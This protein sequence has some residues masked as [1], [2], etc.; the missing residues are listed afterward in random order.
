MGTNGISGLYSGFDTETAIKQMM[1]AERN[2]VN[3]LISSRTTLEWKKDA[4]TEWNNTLKKFREENMSILSDKVNM[5]S[6]SAYK[7]FSVDYSTPSQRYFSA[8]GTSKAQAGTY[9]V[10]AIHQLATGAK[11]ATSGVS[12]GTEGLK[13][14]NVRL[15]EADFLNIPKSHAGSVEVNHFEVTINGIDFTFQKSDTVQDVMN[16]IN[17]SD[18]GVKM[19][20]SQLTDGFTIETTKIGAGAELEIINKR[21]NLFGDYTDSS[22]VE[23][24]SVFGFSNMVGMSSSGAVSGSA[25]HTIDGY[26]GWDIQNIGNHLKTQFQFGTTPGEAIKFELS[27]GVSTETFA[28]DKTASINDIMD[29]V[30]NSSLNIKLAYNKVS[31]AFLLSRTDGDTSKDITVNNMEGNFFGGTLGAGITGIASGTI[32]AANSQLVEV[33][34]GKNA[35][36]TIND[37]L[38]ERESNSFAID[39]INYKLTKT[40]NSTWNSVTEEFEVTADEKS[41]DIELTQNVDEAVKNITNYITEINKLLTGIYGATNEKKDRDYAPLTDE[42]KEAMTE[43]E[44]ELWEAKAKQGQLRR[45]TYLNNFSSSIRSIFSSPI[46]GIGSMESIGIKIGTYLTGQSWQIEVDETK[47]REALEK[48]SNKV[49]EL[50]TH[51]YDEKTDDSKY[52]NDARY[53]ERV[54][55][56][57]SG[58]FKT[59]NTYESMSEAKKKSLNSGF[60][61]LI[62]DALTQFSD[63]VMAGQNVDINGTYTKL[64]SSTQSLTTRIEEY[65]ARIKKEEERLT[66]LEE[67]YWKQF[68]AMETAL[69]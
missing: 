24:K 57:A 33:T 27:D 38:V 62:S 56:R 17:S 39:E 37:V 12:K 52:I 13:D 7:S 19:A 28:F 6:T 9:T 65:S 67:R 63:E 25:E 18:A 55:D 69:S 42:Q 46:A 45:D 2:K 41:I 11:A 35:I 3:K 34:A 66:K 16:K 22:N 8:S 54:Y 23:H 32:S 50:F 14:L 51:V 44:I 36:A 10:N 1:Q 49:V 30:N 26:M 61:V 59:V 43:K 48:D 68:T 31:D 4:Y 20:Y 53:E 29:A 60:S 47:L 21:G 5:M 15:D 40:F 64:S 58:T